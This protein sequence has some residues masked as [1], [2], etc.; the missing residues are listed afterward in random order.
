MGCVAE[1]RAE[2][3]CVP[4]SNNTVHLLSDCG[5]YSGVSNLFR[6]ASVPD[7]VGRSPKTAF[8]FVRIATR[9]V[10]PSRP[11][12]GYPST[13]I[14]HVK[15]SPPPQLPETFGER[16]SSIPRSMLRVS[17]SQLGVRR[18]NPTIVISNE[19]K[20]VYSPGDG[21]A[22]RDQGKSRVQ[23]VQH[24]LSYTEGN[25]KQDAIG[26]S[27]QPSYRS[28]I[29]LEVPLRAS[30]SVVFLD[31]SLLISLLELDGRRAGQPTSYR[32]TLSF[33]L[34]VSSC[35]R[36][37]I[38]NKP[39]KIHEGYRKARVTMLG[40]NKHRIS[41]LGHCRDPL[42][43]PGGPKVEH[44]APTCGV[45][46]KTDDSDTEC[47]GNTL[48]LLS[49]RRTSP[50]NTKAGRQ[51]GNADEAAFLTQR[52]FRHKHHTST[53]GPGTNFIASFQK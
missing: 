36:F 12:P 29:H 8:S 21:L 40:H 6:T 37:P 32:S 27:F 24:R 42:P 39:T 4:W 50:A 20:Q 34:G 30:I 25:G 16:A 2:R 1:A 48:G 33:R 47:H 51:K 3:E 43:K 23:S 52:N 45:N 41:G 49:F 7:E 13:T 18:Q 22:M 31:K 19:F 5:S 9:K 15:V 53:I 46:S 11:G 38:D 17:N 10:L 28:C 14:Q 35:H 44:I 26:G